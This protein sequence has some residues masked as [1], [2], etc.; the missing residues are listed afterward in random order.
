M[1]PAPGI[2]PTALPPTRGPLSGGLIFGCDFAKRG[3]AVRRPLLFVFVELLQGGLY[4]CYDEGRKSTA[5]A[6]YLR[7]HLFDNIVWEPDGLVCCPRHPGYLKFSHA[8]PRIAITKKI[9]LLVARKICIAK[10]MHI[11]Y[12]IRHGGDNMDYSILYHIMF[13]AATDA[14]EVL[15]HG[16]TERAKGLLIAA[17]QLCED[18]YIA[19][20]KEVVS[21]ETSSCMD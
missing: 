4:G 11:E 3:N 14:V 9:V 18:K 5:C 16:D 20:Y 7:L 21:T 12:N 10:A 15:S 8:A 1:T 13:N 17:Q 2:D 19:G 6:D